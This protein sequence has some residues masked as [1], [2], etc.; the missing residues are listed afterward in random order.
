MIVG[1]ICNNSKPND[2]YYTPEYAIKPLMNYLKPKS[3]IWCPFDTIKSNYVKLLRQEHNVVCSH[4]E[5]GEDFFNC[6]VPSCDYIIS[7]PPYSFKNEV[8]ERLFEMKKPFAMLVGVVGLF[9]SKK[10]FEL[11]R[12]NKFEIMY[13]DKRISYFKDYDNPNIKTNPPYSS[14]YICHNIL[15]RNIIFET[16]TK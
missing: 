10:R 12:D 13:F 14:V 15:P 5:T 16:L 2:E 4:I 6:D 7:N 3:L 8:F 9:E 1:K 11:F